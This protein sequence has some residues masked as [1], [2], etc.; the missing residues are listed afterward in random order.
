VGC[1]FSMPAEGTCG[2]GHTYEGVHIWGPYYNEIM[3]QLQYVGN[4]DETMPLKL[5]CVVCFITF[6]VYF[7][8]SCFFYYSKPK[9]QIF[10]ALFT[11]DSLAGKKGIGKYFLV[12]T[13]YRRKI[14]TIHQSSQYAKIKWLSHALALFLFL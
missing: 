8:C 4:T 13:N 6:L 3:I 5:A 14:K 9:F 12:K 2:C 1:P 7:Q 10:Q 11:A